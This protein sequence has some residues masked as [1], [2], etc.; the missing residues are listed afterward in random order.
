MKKILFITYY[1]PPAVGAGVQRPMTLVKNLMQF[2]INT[3]TVILVQF[4]IMI[5]LFNSF[6]SKLVNRLFRGN[7]V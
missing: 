7:H 1:F 2:V 5:V 6:K 4:L 3:C